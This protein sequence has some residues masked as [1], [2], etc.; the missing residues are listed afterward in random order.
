MA[1]FR[2]DLTGPSTMWTQTNTG[3]CSLSFAVNTSLHLQEATEINFTTG[4]LLALKPVRPARQELLMQNQDFEFL[5]VF[6]HHG[7]S[8]L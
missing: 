5:R 8:F 4:L 7:V 6:S 1:A 3:I 2:G